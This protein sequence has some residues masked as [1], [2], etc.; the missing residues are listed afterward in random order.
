MQ[1]EELM[2]SPVFLALTRPTMFLG[3]TAEYLFFCFVVSYGAF[4]LTS[5]PLFMILWIPLHIFGIIVCRIDANYFRV[6][7]KNSEC[8]GTMNKKIWGTKN[9]EP[10]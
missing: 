6:I 2:I 1:E 8:P 9:Y 10:F 3:V 4:A 7:L 5:H